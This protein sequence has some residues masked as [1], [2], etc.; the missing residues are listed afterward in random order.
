MTL[1]KIVSKNLREVR[2]QQRLSQETIAKRSGISV[3][4]VSMLER[5]QRT[6]RLETLE[7][8]AKALR[9]SP[10]YLMQELD[11]RPRKPRRD[12]RSRA[13]FPSR[14]QGSRAGRR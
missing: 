8:L 10:L 5:G 12:W 7:S 4:Y 3:S 11:G 13:G 1:R 2:T 6:P 9:V 14:R